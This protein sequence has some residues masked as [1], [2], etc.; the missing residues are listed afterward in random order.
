MYYI[1][2][3]NNNFDGLSYYTRL[4]LVVGFLLISIIGIH[5][6]EPELNGSSLRANIIRYIIALIFFIRIWYVSISKS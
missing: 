4:I 2:K 6:F 1:K 3:M 5:F